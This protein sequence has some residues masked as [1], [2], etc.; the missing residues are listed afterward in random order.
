MK[1]SNELIK[2]KSKDDFNK[3]NLK[4]YKL[5]MEDTLFAS[6]AYKLEL[7]ESILCKYTSKLES[8]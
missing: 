2:N 1:N 5:A 8:R 3:V 4:N 6:L 7:D